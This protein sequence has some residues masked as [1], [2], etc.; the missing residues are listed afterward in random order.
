M[1]PSQRPAMPMASAI[2]SLVLGS[3][4]PGLVAATAMPEKAAGTS[5][6]ALR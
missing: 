4:A 1:Q 6:A 5:G 3:S 2:S